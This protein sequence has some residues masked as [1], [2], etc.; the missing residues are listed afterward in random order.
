MRKHY[1]YIYILFIYTH[2]IIHFPTKLHL[3][4]NQYIKPLAR[5]HTLPTF[6]LIHKHQALSPP[7]LDNIIQTLQSTLI[8]FYPLTCPTNFNDYHSPYDK[9]KIFGSQ[10]PPFSTQWIGNGYSH[11]MDI[12]FLPKLL[13]W[14]RL[15]TLSNPNSTTIIIITHDDW[16]N[17][18]SNPIQHA[19]ATPII[20][21]PPHDYAILS[22][23]NPCNILPPF[24]NKSYVLRNPWA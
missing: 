7:I 15:T 13:K 19:H 22:I 11:I 21:I 23:S 20:T 8:P 12:D 9:D 1:I 5:R 2:P 6:P 10:G 3:F 17:N 14:A 18:T 4:I 24:Q 16:S